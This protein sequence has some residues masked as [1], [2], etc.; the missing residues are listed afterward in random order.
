VLTGMPPLMPTAVLMTVELAVYGALA[1]VLYNGL[2]WSLVSSLIGSMLGGRI[3]YG[4][5]RAYVV[6][7]FGIE[8]IP[9]F[10]WITSTLGT[11][12]PGIIIQ[13]V[14]VPLVVAAA[15]R[16]PLFAHLKRAG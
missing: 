1:G 7:L 8:G 16:M 12:W 2:R 14:V 15:E 13:L 3:I 4:V 9:M 11:S 10:V 5:L 6:P